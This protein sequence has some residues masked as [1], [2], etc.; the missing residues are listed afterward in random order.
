MSNV[1][2]DGRLVKGYFASFD[3]I[4]SHGDMFVK[5]AFD[6][7]LEKWGVNG[8]DSR[9][10]KHLAFHDQT[11]IAGDLKKLGEDDKGLFFESLMLETTLGNDSLVLYKTLNSLEHSVGYKNVAYEIVTLTDAEVLAMSSSGVHEMGYAKRNN[12]YWKLKEVELYEGSY[13]SFGSNRFTQNLTNVKSQEGL[14]ALKTK[15]ME[16]IDLVSK[17]ISDCTIVEF[18]ELEVLKLKEMITQIDTFE[19]EK[20]QSKKTIIFEPEL[21]I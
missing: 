8:T 2:I 18:L 13:V 9:R 17:C 20:I 3:T 6:K 19:P 21:F 14:N 4:D 1:E 10:I 7:S 16:Q 12:E 11:Q 15:V 5:G